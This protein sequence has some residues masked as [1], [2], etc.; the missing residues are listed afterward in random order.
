MVSCATLLVC[1]CVCLLY[2]IACLLARWLYYHPINVSFWLFAEQHKIFHS[3]KIVYI[4]SNRTTF[5]MREF[6]TISDDSG[7]SW[8]SRTSY[9]PGRRPIGVWKLT[10]RSSNP[11]ILQS[12]GG[13]PGPGN[14]RVVGHPKQGFRP[15]G[16]PG[17]DFF[18]F[19]HPFSD[20]DLGCLRQ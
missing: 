12:S 2:L 17:L 13:P 6:K 19:G 3:L 5:C 8:A 10:S 7:L 9:S 1:G 4:F 14:D 16:V 20:L 18:D 11:S 15:F